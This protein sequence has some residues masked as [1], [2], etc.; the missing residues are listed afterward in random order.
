[1]TF[2]EIKRRHKICQTC[3]AAYC[4]ITKRFV[5]VTCSSECAVKCMVAKRQKTGSYVRTNEQNKKLSNTLKKQYSSG[6]R[7][8]TVNAMLAVSWTP[9]RLAKREKTCKEHFGYAHWSQTA[10]GK[11]Q[12][13]QV[14]TGK[15]ISLEQR[16]AVS[17]A[18]KKR[19]RSENQYSHCKKGKR[20]DLGDIFFRSAWEANYARILNY[21]GIIW[22]YEPETFQISEIETYTPDFKLTDGTF[23][24]IK[25]W[26]TETSK[27]KIE[28]FKQKYPDIKLQIIGKM[29]YKILSKQY[30]HNI[31]HWE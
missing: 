12:N 2:L 3:G 13:S 18:S 8:P 19:L 15:I 28:L 23:I 1:M 24:E 17:E 25:G 7:K 16:K 22:Q 30:C 20:T 6:E 11:K 10:E 14:N 4:D 26:W 27:R 29:E 21:L 31:K 5:G 9:E